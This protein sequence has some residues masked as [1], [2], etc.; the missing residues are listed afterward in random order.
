MDGHLKK[1]KQQL[2]FHSISLW[3]ENYNAMQNC[4]KQMFIL[5]IILLY[6]E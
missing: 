3:V 4:K 1:K 6:I 5:Y 2:A